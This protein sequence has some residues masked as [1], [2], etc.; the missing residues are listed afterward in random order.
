MYPGRLLVIG[1]LGAQVVRTAP[2]PPTPAAPVAGR[3]QTTRVVR[4][5]P[6]PFP[7][8]RVTHTAPIFCDEQKA[9]PISDIFDNG[10]WGT[11]PLAGALWEQVDEAVPD[12]AD[13]L[14]SGATKS[15]CLL[16]LT[17]LE[18]PETNTG[19]FLRLL[20]S[21]P[22][23][24]V[25]LTIT[26]EQTKVNSPTTVIASFV[27]G[28]HPVIPTFKDYAIFK[29]QADL[30]TDYKKLAI[31][32]VTDA[33]ATQWDVGWVQLFAP[34]PGRLESSYINKGTR[35][36]SGEPPS[37]PGARVI[38]PRATG[39]VVAAPSNNQFVAPRIVR[40]EVPLPDGRVLR[41]HKTPAAV[42]TFHQSVLAP[43]MVR[44][45]APPHPTS[46]V[47]QARRAA[48]VQTF[49]QSALR[50]WRITR[51]DAPPLPKA[52]VIKTHKRPAAVDTFHQESTDTRVVRGD[53][54]PFPPARIDQFRLQHTGRDD[55]SLPARIVRG[56]EPSLPDARVVRT[57][58]RAAAVQTFSQ[59]AT[60]PFRITRGDA[61][62]LPGAQVTRSHKVS[63]E[64][65]SFQLNL[66]PT[67][68]VRGDEPPLPDGAVNQTSLF[69]TGRD[70]PSLP[71]RIVRGDAPPAPGSRVVTTGHRYQ[72]RP[73]A[74]TFHQAVLSPRIVT[75]DPPALPGAR[76][77]RQQVF[78]DFIPAPPA[79]LHIVETRMVRGQA[80]TPDGS[81]VKTGHQ[82]QLHPTAPTF[83]QAV[84]YLRSVQGDAPPRP[85][86]RAVKNQLPAP[87]TPFSILL[88]VPRSVRGDPPP[89]P[90]GWRLRWG[91]YHTGLIPIVGTA[92]GFFG[93]KTFT[94]FL[95]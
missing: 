25:T 74:P 8:A 86:A 61:P 70:D 44:G 35:I 30:I 23:G 21:R 54:P 32:L 58:K 19:H 94:E 15:E 33:G 37:L 7:S 55:P 65:E 56:D 62:P 36:V 18:D 69:H 10:E 28:F 5:D 42:Q 12:N 66:L 49:N 67:Q 53:A 76:V 51:G 38:Q 40:G 24:G 4:A 84:V 6:P 43:R 81:I 50:P 11:Q 52:Q 46:D 9:R 89:S 68:V 2:V 90:E 85:G 17:P 45:D 39:P 88:G 48:A 82:V 92:R 34:C 95:K 63:A 64:E 72:L 59:L 93:R 29:S 1:L 73:T 78:T 26:L 13:R 22:V 60:R 31:R 71:S 20:L 91:L 83:H 80:P 3:L 16:E 87:P 57:H 14:V 79:I 41:L 77:G 27:Q 75:G 47:T